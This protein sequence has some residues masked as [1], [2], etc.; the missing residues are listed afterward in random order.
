M[1]H[2]FFFFTPSSTPHSPLLCLIIDSA[3]VCHTHNISARLCSCTLLVAV[4]ES[5]QICSHCQWKEEGRATTLSLS[6]IS[7]TWSRRFSEKLNKIYHFNG[8]AHSQVHVVFGCTY[9]CCARSWRSSFI[10]CVR[11]RSHI[12]RVVVARWVIHMGRLSGRFFFRELS[13]TSSFA[14]KCGFF[15]TTRTQQQHNI[16]ENFNIPTWCSFAALKKISFSRPW[17]Y[18][19][20]V[21]GYGN[22][23]RE[24]RPKRH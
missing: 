4:E 22:I 17:P 1:T 21:C 18:I 14:A 11:A 12:R 9:K 8:E 15:A 7:W 10:S 5:L 19:Y 2:V 6:L 20:C 23:A 3:A 13:Q 16:S 24:S